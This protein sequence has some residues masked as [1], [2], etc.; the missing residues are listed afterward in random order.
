M[1][2]FYFF[3]QPSLKFIRKNV[4]EIIPTYDSNLTFSLIKMFDCFIQPFRPREVRFK[5]IRNL[6][7]KI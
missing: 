5:D 3:L 1:K 7:I 6:I 2:S 4:K